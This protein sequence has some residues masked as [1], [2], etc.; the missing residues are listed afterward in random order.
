[1]YEG[2]RDTPN[3]VG[4]NTLRLALDGRMTR[5]NFDNLVK[6]SRLCSMWSS[7]TVTVDELMVVTDD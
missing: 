1:M 7:R 5:G 2:I 4:R 6:L 3:E